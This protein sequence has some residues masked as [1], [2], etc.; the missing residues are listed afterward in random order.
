MSDYQAR[1]PSPKGEPRPF[2]RVDDL[3]NIKVCVPDDPPIKANNPKLDKIGKNHVKEYVPDANF[4][5]VS[6]TDETGKN[7]VEYVLDGNFHIIKGFATIEWKNKEERDR[8]FSIMKKEE[9]FRRIDEFVKDMNDGKFPSH[10]HVYLHSLLTGR[11]YL[12][13]IDGTRRMLTYL[14]R[15]EGKDIP[16]VI[17]TA[18]WWNWQT[19]KIQNLVPERRPSST[20]GEATHVGDH[21]AIPSR[22]RV[23]LWNT[24]HKS[25]RGRR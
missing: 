16:V 1:I 9:R 24:R 11:E 19:R 4:S 25:N 14:E 12:I 18:P 23:A 10:A 8:Y 5:E 2:T 7:H 22:I 6:V 17:I 20:P 21:C 13:A 3:V 15:E